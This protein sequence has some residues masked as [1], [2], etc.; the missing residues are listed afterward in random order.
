MYSKR[1]GDMKFG[2]DF[3]KKLN[4]VK[5]NFKPPLS[6]GKDH[7]GFIAQEVRDILPKGDYNFITTKKL[8][9]LSEGQNS[10]FLAINYQ[11]FVP[12][13]VKAVQELSEKV[14]RLEKKTKK[15]KK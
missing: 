9:S 1:C 5:F 11:Q 12:C 15:I 4:P 7:F 10:E 3:I 6:D 13:L 8:S 14:E 2:L